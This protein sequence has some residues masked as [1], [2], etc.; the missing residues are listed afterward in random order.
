MMTTDYSLK[1][2]L[3]IYASGVPFNLIHAVITVVILFFINKPM[4]VKFT[5]LRIKYGIF[6]L[7]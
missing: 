2:V 5:R 7:E 1:T 4:T 3:G 6:E